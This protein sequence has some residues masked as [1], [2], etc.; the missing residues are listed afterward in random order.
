MADEHSARATG[1]ARYTAEELK[2]AK[3]FEKLETISVGRALANLGYLNDGQIASTEEL[4]EFHDYKLSQA[5]EAI[6]AINDMKSLDELKAYFLSL[7]SIGS[8][9]DVW[10]AKET[11]KKELS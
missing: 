5:M 2:K 6:E 8:N 4:E 11:K 9:K 7:G 3:S 1:N 10:A